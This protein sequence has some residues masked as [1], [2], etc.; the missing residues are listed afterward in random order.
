[1][2]NFR[3]NRIGAHRVFSKKRL[4]FKTKLTMLGAVGA[5]II[6]FLIVEGVASL[7][8]NYDFGEFTKNVLSSITTGLERDEYG[9]INV[10]LL[11]AGGEK[12]EGGT[13]TDTLMVAGLNPSKKTAAMLSIPR[14]LY[15]KTENHNGMRVNSIFELVTA[16]TG[17]PEEGLNVLNEAIENVT[18]LK[19]PYYIKM[20]FQGLEDAVDALGGV[21]VYV[22]ETINDP[23]YP[24][25][26]T[27]GYSPFYLTAG[28]HTLDGK[29]ALKYVRSRKTT[30]DF[31]RARRQQKLIFA[32]KEK[33]LSSDILTSPGKIKAL[34]E[35]FSNNVET[36]MSI[37]ELIGL[38]E[39]GADLTEE[40]IIKYVLHDDFT[41]QGGFLYPPLREEY[42]GAF[43]LLP[44]GDNF[45]HIQ[46]FIR[47]I[48]GESDIMTRENKIQILNGTHRNLLA[49]STKMILRKYGFAVERFGNATSKEIQET[50][51][52][53]RTEKEPEVIKIL[54][55]L[56]PGKVVTK[57][58][59]TYQEPPYAGNAD[60]V[61]ELGADFL[62]VF[63]KLDVFSGIVIYYGTENKEEE[64]DEEKTQNTTESTEKPEN[65]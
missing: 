40:N 42:G 49:G 16:K 13:L 48:F 59:Q 1:M 62:P 50:T 17:N 10:L 9:N 47:F 23:F 38:A 34:Y 14:D 46:R 33:A 24:K 58:P 54:R 28:N 45:D 11:G 39:K 15:I 30:S 63:D 43:V 51:Y 44:A 20:D 4:P 37:R 36:N 41:K 60:M 61:I 52:Y 8:T 3:K 19:I 21:P 53:Y 27:I 64:K 6:L 65:Q 26:G 12:H 56:V 57:I 25:D 32:I 18:G 55:E 2:V 35:S 22:D 29:T 7:A 31:D 5:L